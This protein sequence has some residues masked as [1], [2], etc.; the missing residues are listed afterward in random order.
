MMLQAANPFWFYQVLH[1]L[2]N[3]FETYRINSINFVLKCR[4]C[5]V[6]KKNNSS[7]AVAN[8]NFNISIK[9]YKVYFVKELHNDLACPGRDLGAT[10]VSQISSVLQK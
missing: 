10:H 6:L 1:L 7:I 9:Y 4:E 5:F 8:Q 3:I 2:V